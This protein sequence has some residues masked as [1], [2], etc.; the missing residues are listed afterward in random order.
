FNITL[1]ELFE[2]ST[3]AEL[4]PRLLAA[5]NT[6]EDAFDVL[7]PIKPQGT[8]PP[9]FCVHHG[10]GLSWSYIGLS[11]YMHP[12]QPLYGL[13]V[14]GFFDNDQPAASVEDM[15]IDYIDQIRRVQPH[16]P[17][18]LLGYSLGGMIAHTMAAHLERQGEIVMLLAIMDS[19]PDLSKEPAMSQQEE[20]YDKTKFIGWFANRS[21]E[22]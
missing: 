15:A 6:Q 5:G 13:Q 9:L 21:N 10:F 14:R 2:A 7:L 8:R 22:E 19:I 3:I 18:Y 11:K 1:G 20:P 17:Y 4:V 12:D 16:G